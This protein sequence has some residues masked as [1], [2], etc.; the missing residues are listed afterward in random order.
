[1]LLPLAVLAED[2][3]KKDKAVQ[4]FQEGKRL[5]QNKEFK[6]AA[7]AFRLAN[8]LRRSWKLLYNI[9]Q[10]E[11]AAK[12]YGRALDA[13][14]RYMAEG[15][16]DIPEGRQQYVLD[17]ISRLRRMVGFVE[18]IGEVGDKVLVDGVLRMSL[19]QES[20]IRVGMGPRRVRVLR[21]EEAVYD[22]TVDILGGELTTV[23]VQTAQSAQS[24][25][26]EEEPVSAATA[27]AEPETED[28]SQ[29]S[30]QDDK[31]DR[32]RLWTWVAFGVGGA[33]GIA[34]AVLGGV[35]LSKKNEFVDDCG[36]N[37]CT[38]ERSS[39][40]DTVNNMALSADIMYGVAGLGVAAGLVLFF[41]EPR[42]RQKKQMESPQVSLLPTGLVL[43][44]SF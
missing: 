15:G 34:G 26:P 5:F 29:P 12:R 28:P 1:M 43:S 13:F 42:I 7:E 10:C 38:T 39:D 35:A 30:P 16:D 36:D 18:V 23:N 32:K 11:A 40:R 6:E 21:S 24:P 8:H 27:G 4:A 25:M 3:E 22:S 37:S 9:G 2:E 44:G 31:G 19:P 33:A 41:L 20:K 17:E 14:E